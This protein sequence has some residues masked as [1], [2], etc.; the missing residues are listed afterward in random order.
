MTYFYWPALWLLIFFLIVLWRLFYRPFPKVGVLALSVIPTWILD[1]L[2]W[3]TNFYQSQVL[4][5]LVFWLVVGA[6]WSFVFVGKKMTVMSFLEKYWRMTG[7]LG[8]TMMVILTI[9]TILLKK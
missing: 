6:I 1:H 7:L 9:L 8:I 5:V 2:T 4:A 3:G